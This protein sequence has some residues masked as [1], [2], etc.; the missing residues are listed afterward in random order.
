MGPVKLAIQIVT[1]VSMPPT[2]MFA[3]RMQLS[4]VLFVNLPNVLNLVPAV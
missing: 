4:S 3:S 1:L 2:A